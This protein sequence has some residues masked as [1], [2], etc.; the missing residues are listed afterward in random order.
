MSAVQSVLTNR[1]LERGS[2]RPTWSRFGRGVLSVLVA[3]LVAR[4]V[5]VRPTQVAAL[6]LT[7]SVALVPRLG[8]RPGRAS[9]AHG[10]RLRRALRHGGRRLPDPRA[11]RVRRPLRAG[12]GCSRSGWPA[13]CCSRPS[14]LLPWLRRP[15]PPRYWGKVVAATPGHRA[16]RRRRRRAA[17]P[18]HRAPARRRAR[19][20]RRVVRPAGLVAVAQ[21][22]TATGSRRAGS[23]RPA[24]PA[25]AVLLLWVG[26]TLPSRV[27]DIGPVAFVRLPLEV[28]VL[29]ALALRRC[30]GGHANVTA[31][32]VGVRAGAGDDREGPRHGLLLR[33]EP[34]LRPRHRLDLRRF[35]CSACC[36]T[37][38]STPAA[39][40]MLSP[41]GGA[42]S[43]RSSC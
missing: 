21:P 26:L 39:I 3:A 18:G 40:V 8:R 20:A 22:V 23:R 42:C 4:V 1:V 6:V 5:L 32:A 12:R 7:S 35:R 24:D 28:L 13:T 38:S 31:V 19:A 17:G 25:A 41:G 14:R 16:D 15:S 10:V 34:L 9:Y 27:E 43:S 2:D 11:Q 37:R 30:P 33:A 36:A 29:V